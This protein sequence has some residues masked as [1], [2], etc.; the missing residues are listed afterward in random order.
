MARNI[1]L[2]QQ[3]RAILTFLN[4]HLKKNLLTDSQK[5]WHIPEKHLLH[6]AVYN[7]PC[8]PYAAALLLS[9]STL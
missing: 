5:I 8:Q 3:T 6:E 9:P 7:D 4:E 1:S 2:D